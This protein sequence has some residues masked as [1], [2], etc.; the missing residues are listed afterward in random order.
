MAKTR[1]IAMVLA[2]I[3]MLLSLSALSYAQ[4]R[5]A[6]DATHNVKAYMD[7]LGWIRIPGGHGDKAFNGARLNN[8]NQ[9]K[10]YVKEAQ[11]S[12]KTG[13][14]GYLKIAGVQGVGYNQF[15]RVIAPENL[16]NAYVQ[17]SSITNPEYMPVYYLFNK[18]G[19]NM[20]GVHRTQV[21]VRLRDPNN[22]VSFHGQ[23][24]CYLWFEPK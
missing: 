21:N 9:L 13:Y 7:P 11:Y 19:F 15:G 18:T 23:K 3:M 12:G 20:S 6:T 4:P 22:N 17:G 10:V 2:M 1:R 8:P 14:I 5:T 16:K 24:T